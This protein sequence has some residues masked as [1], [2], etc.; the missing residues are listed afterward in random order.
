MWFPRLF[1]SHTLPLFKAL[2]SNLW[3]LI[4][5]CSKHSFSFITCWNIS[6]ISS[7]APKH[8][9]SHC[10]ACLAACNC[11]PCSSPGAGCWEQHG[12]PAALSCCWCKAVVL[13]RWCGTGGEGCRAA[14]GAVLGPPSGEW[15]LPSNQQSGLDQNSKE[16]TGHQKLATRSC[17][18]EQVPL[19]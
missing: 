6:E 12:A 10:E 2:I 19:L 11:F 16:E 1:L 9:V 3:F 18:L 13:G 14:G 7:L 15:L 8:A 4:V 5:Y 17:V